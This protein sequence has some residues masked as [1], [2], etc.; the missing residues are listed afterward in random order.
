[1]TII[2]MYLSLSPTFAHLFQSLKSGK[3]PYSHFLHT[4]LGWYSQKQYCSIFKDFHKIVVWI[5]VFERVRF[6]LLNLTFVM[7][8]ISNWL[9]KLRKQTIFCSAC[10]V[11]GKIYLVYIYNLLLGVTAKI[12]VFFLAILCLYLLCPSI[13]VYCTEHSFKQK[14]IHK[15]GVKMHLF[16][17]I[18]I[19]TGTWPL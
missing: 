9:T 2:Q 12:E 10:S 11:I 14:K 7:D 3:T 1:M 13:L 16:K 15:F 5:L 17:L 19:D 4:M 8:C 18:I 6:S